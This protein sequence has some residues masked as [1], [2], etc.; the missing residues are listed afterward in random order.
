MESDGTLKAFLD[1]TVEA[2]PK[3]EPEPEPQPEPEPEKP[4]LPRLLKDLNLD[5]Y[6]S[7]FAELGVVKIDH[8]SD[9]E[10]VRTATRACNPFY[11]MV[12]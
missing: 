1:T 3:V 10:K 8:I 5:Q 4:D 9:L 2:K 11:H 12:L 7:A 6:A